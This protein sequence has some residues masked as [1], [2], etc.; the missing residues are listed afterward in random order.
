MGQLHAP[1]AGHP[2]AAGRM[3]T[4]PLRRQQR[5]S[6]RACAMHPLRQPTDSDTDAA[7][8]QVATAETAPSQEQRLICG[9]QHASNV[10]TSNGGSTRYT[11]VH[12]GRQPN[13]PGVRYAHPASSLSRALCN[14]VHPPAAAAHVQY[15]GRKHQQAPGRRK[16][17]AIYFTPIR[18]AC[19]TVHPAREA[20]AHVQS[21][22]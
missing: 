12:R 1:A 15:T 18:T 5:Q 19:P 11:A 10:R 22:F 14:T 7:K 13:T 16:R 21:I 9:L 4:N 6:A 2:P 3:N 8:G 17:N 20:R